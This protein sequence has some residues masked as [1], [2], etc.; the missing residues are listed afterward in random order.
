MEHSQALVTNDAVVL[1]MR[2]GTDKFQPEVWLTTYPAPF[3]TQLLELTTAN[4]G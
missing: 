3:R 1:G 4:D 2:N